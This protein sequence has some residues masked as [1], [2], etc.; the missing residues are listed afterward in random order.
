MILLI[1]YDLRSPGRDYQPLQ[2]E[3]KKLGHQWWHHM[4][5]TWL[6]QT[7]LSPKDCYDR[8]AS[9]LV[10]PDTVL[11][12]EITPNCWGVLPEIAWKWIR[13]R[14]AEEGRPMNW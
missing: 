8:L 1:T 6:V 9:H 13:D 5:S 10:N 7:Q 12:V 3:I 2:N 4:E 14:F 11:V